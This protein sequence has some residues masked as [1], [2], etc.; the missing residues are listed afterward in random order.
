[1]TAD[2]E[3]CILTNHV[4]FTRGSRTGRACALAF[5]VAR[6]RC[7]TV[8]DDS[9]RLRAPWS[10]SDGSTPLHVAMAAGRVSAT[11]LLI[12]QGADPERVND[13]GYLP[14]H[15]AAVFGSVATLDALLAA[16]LAKAEAATVRDLRGVHRGAERESGRGG[17][18]GGG[19]AAEPESV[20]DL[21]DTSSTTSLRDATVSRPP[22]A[23]RSTSARAS[24]SRGP[25]TAPELLLRWRTHGTA[26]T[27]RELER[28][29][30]AFIAIAVHP[31][32]PPHSI[33]GSQPGS[34]T[35]LHVA[36]AEGDPAMVRHLLDL[37][38][39]V[40]VR[41]EDGRSALACAV[42]AGRHEGCLV[43]AAAVRRSG[44]DLGRLLDER[45]AV[46]ERFRAREGRTKEWS[47]WR[48]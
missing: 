41:D 46:R 17:G 8:D 25:H 36:A 19:R 28:S 16:V 2:K 21:A 14:V 1:M 38:C 47:E 45:D 4:M 11:K 27:V 26:V 6:G 39:A 29:R 43:L 30:F 7:E 32:P 24:A 3:G 31:T 9:R 23:R 20:A 10:Q 34:R 40:E 33:P 44:G 35:A 37:G 13:A 42:S 5:G 48:H 18:V 15:L 22:A 12:A